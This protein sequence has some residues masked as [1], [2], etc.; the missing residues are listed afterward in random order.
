V[1]VKL[2]HSNQP[3]LELTCPENLIDNITTEIIGDTLVIKNTN[4]FNWIRSYDYSIDLTVYYDS[5]REINYASIGDLYCAEHD[6]IRGVL[7]QLTDT[8]E[9]VVIPVFP[10]VFHLNVNEGSG[11]INLLFNCDVLKHKFGNGT[12]CVT[13]RG[14][15]GY[16]EHL[17]R[18]YGLIHA[19]E[20][21]SNFVVVQSESTND[22]YVWAKTNLKVY[23]YNIGNVY[24]K[25]DPEWSIL[26][27]TNNGRLIPME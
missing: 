7:T 10:H 12:S 26:A 2:K 9:G 4:K 22:T 24:Y 25:G 11:D 20:M 17:T 6:S 21:S 14:K 3:H 5:L 15:V 13:C 23:L 16:S 19:E 27:C 18:S 8:V 1:N